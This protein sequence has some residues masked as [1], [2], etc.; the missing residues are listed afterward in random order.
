[1]SIGVLFKGVA[2][3]KKVMESAN[4]PFCVTRMTYLE[5]IF[6]IDPENKKH[7]EEEK[8]YDDFFTT[9]PTFELTD[10]ACKKAS[11]LFWTLKKQGQLI[12]QADCLI[13]AIF[14]NN[15]IK[16]IITRNKKHF[17]RISE[18]TAIPY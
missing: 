1:M 7:L 3:I 5:L 11:R 17:D 14:L 8:Y 12:E 13:S 6:G 4:E 9:L 2:E 18:L 15:G 16:K 10:L